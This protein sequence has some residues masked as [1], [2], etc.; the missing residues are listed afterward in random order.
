MQ[1]DI[2]ANGDPV[3]GDLTGGSLPQI[4]VF[5]D[6]TLIQ[7]DASVSRVIYETRR[8][9]GLRQIIANGELHYTGTLQDS[10]FVESGN[11]S[12][13][14]LARNFNILN[15]T[16]GV[17]LVLGNNLIITPTM[18]VPLRDGLDEQFDYEANVQVNLLR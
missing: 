13:T 6:S 17:H 15:A 5:N 10:D 11:L 1:L 14:S 8:S 16:A 9:R 4:G 2:A 18:S 3:F 12:F 7:L